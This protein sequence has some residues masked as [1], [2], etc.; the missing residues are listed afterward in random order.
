MD[1]HERYERDR[2]IEWVRMQPGAQLLIERSKL[3]LILLVILFALIVI[4]W[5]WPN[6][7]KQALMPLAKLVVAL[8][9]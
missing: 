6:A 8:G 7:I 4:E 9:F 3:V 2:N 1:Y 5:V